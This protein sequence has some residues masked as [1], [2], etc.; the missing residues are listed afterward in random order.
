MDTDTLIKKFNIF[1]C[2]GMSYATMSHKL[3][4]ENNTKIPVA[5]SYL[6]GSM[7]YFLSAET[8]Y[9]AK[10]DVLKNEEAE[11]IF[12]HFKKFANELLKSASVNHSYQWTDIEF[13]RLSDVFNSSIFA[14]EKF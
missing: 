6:N 10:Y 3:I 12:F 13:E 11:K 7:S 9:Y 5:L 2:S 8:L 4:L 14:S 1:I